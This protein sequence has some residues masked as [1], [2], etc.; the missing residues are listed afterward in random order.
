MVSS[1]DG[2]SNSIAPLRPVLPGNA[3]P[4]MFKKDVESS[5]SLIAGV[6]VSVSW[7]SKDEPFGDDDKV[8]IQIVGAQKQQGEAR[9]NVFSN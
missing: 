9:E 1:R 7:P 2:V 5:F 4:S 3:F 8:V 6:F